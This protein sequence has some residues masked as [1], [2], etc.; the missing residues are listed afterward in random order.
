VVEEGKHF[1]KKVKLKL[2]CCCVCCVQIAGDEC[3]SM[4]LLFFDLKHVFHCAT[5]FSKKVR[6]LMPIIKD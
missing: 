6:G 1:V 3:P 4:D 2:W 5:S